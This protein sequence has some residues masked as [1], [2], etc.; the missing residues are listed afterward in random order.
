MRKLPIDQDK[1][2]NYVL[3]PYKRDIEL[4]QNA[5][6]LTKDVQDI[7]ER[8]G[9]QRITELALAAKGNLVRLLALLEPK[10]EPVGP[11]DDDTNN[12]TDN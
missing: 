10:S 12:P 9:M 1:D 6:V 4:L 11:V 5:S 7:A 2:G 3:R 8:L